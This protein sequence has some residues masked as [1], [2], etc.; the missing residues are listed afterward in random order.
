MKNLIGLT[1]TIWLSL[2]IAA[3]ANAEGSKSQNPWQNGDLEIPTA[4]LP[5]NIDLADCT[6]VSTTDSGTTYECD[7]GKVFGTFTYF[8]PAD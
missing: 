4:Y 2:F 6:L 1:L 5:L 3:T 8:V 7:G